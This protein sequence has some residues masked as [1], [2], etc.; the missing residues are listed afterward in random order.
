MQATSCSVPLPRPI[1]L[2]N[3][4]PLSDMKRK[5]RHHS[6]ELSMKFKLKT[7]PDDDR[8]QM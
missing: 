4:P 7:D 6:L 1:I 8:F 5:C 3:L 2:C